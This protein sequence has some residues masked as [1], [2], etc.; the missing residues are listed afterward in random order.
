[1]T[2]WLTNPWGVAGL[3]VGVGLVHCVLGRQWVA[4]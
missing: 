4:G 2:G 3:V 1:M